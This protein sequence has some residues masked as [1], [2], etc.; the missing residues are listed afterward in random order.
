MVPPEVPNLEDCELEEDLFRRRAAQDGLDQKVKEIYLTYAAV[1]IP[2][3][4]YSLR[5][6][7]SL[8]ERADGPI[9]VRRAAHAVTDERGVLTSMYWMQARTGRTDAYET[10]YQKVGVF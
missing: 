8:Q 2:H 10:P 1:R 9:A 3:S 5:V 4:S 6:T 7:R